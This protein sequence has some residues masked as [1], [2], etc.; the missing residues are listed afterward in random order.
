MTILGW[1]ATTGNA[2]GH[3]ERDEEQCRVDEED[4]VNAK[5]ESVKRHKVSLMSEKLLPILSLITLVC[6]MM[7]RRV[8]PSKPL[9]AEIP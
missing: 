3:A 7:R 8:D 9:R 1:S 4:Y 2:T 6:A 5:I